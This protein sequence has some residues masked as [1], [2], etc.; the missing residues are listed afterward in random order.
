MFL[1]TFLPL[2]HLYIW[3]CWYFSAIDFGN[4]DSS[5]CFIQPGILYLIHS[6]FFKVSIGTISILW[7][8]KLRL[9]MI[10]WPARTFSVLF[11]RTNTLSVLAGCLSLHVC[12]INNMELPMQPH[13]IVELVKWCYASLS[14]LYHR[15]LRIQWPVLET[16]HCCEQH[17]CV[18]GPTVLQNL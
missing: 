5:L 7:V 12:L 9:S 11:P 15:P 17:A 4:L 6:T 10:R 16:V 2:Y 18:K 14:C 1:F 3:S 8:Q 13:G